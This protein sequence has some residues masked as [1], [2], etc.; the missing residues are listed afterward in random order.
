MHNLFE[1]TQDSFIQ[2]Y[3]LLR[4][5]CQV[6]PAIVSFQERSKV[7]GINILCRCYLGRRKEETTVR[8]RGRW[9]TRRQGWGRKGDGYCDWLLTVVLSFLAAKVKSTDDASHGLRHYFKKGCYPD[10]GCPK[11][12][13]TRIY[14]KTVKWILDTVGTRWDREGGGFSWEG[15]GSITGKTVWNAA[16][17]GAEVVLEDPF[18]SNTETRLLECFHEITERMGMRSR[19]CQSLLDALN[20][21]KEEMGLA[22]GFLRKCCV[23]S[24]KAHTLWASVYTSEP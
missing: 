3:N 20:G 19:W 10:S 4:H 13:V 15:A 21:G 12:S 9:S 8:K 17:L 5:I 6:L 2:V 23:T 1:A 16:G 22:Q 24:G 14:T 7:R 18:W 11:W